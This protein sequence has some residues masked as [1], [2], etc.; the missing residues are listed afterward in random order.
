F[1][2]CCGALAAASP[3]FALEGFRPA[4]N[5]LPKSVVRAVIQTRDGYLWLG[6]PEGLA[7]FDGVNFTVFDENKTPGLKSRSIVS[8]YEDRQNNLW[9]GTENAGVALV[10]DGA[11][12]NLGIGQMKAACEDLHGAVWL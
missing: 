4:P 5:G 10:K 12:T 6:T 1:A 9:V 2:P 11:V 3:S 8:L 7:R